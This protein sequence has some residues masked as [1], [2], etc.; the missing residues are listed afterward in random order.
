MIQQ[1]LVNE[2]SLN[3]SELFIIGKYVKVSFKNGI[4]MLFSE[5]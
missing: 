1:K 3:F 5:F 2:I 4:I